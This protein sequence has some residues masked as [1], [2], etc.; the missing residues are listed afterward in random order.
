[1]FGDF[2]FLFLNKKRL[3]YLLYQKVLFLSFGAEPVGESASATPGDQYDTE[4]EVFC[5]VRRIGYMWHLRKNFK[6]KFF[7]IFFIYC[8]Q[9]FY[10]VYCVP[11]CL[12]LN[13]AN[14]SQQSLK[15]IQS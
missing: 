6:K 5:L 3:K 13:K 15:M 10:S 14:Y 2:F 12:L 9:F 4:A 1:M 8:R 11:D 7:F